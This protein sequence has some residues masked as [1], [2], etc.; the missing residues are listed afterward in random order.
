MIPR[1]LRS[2][3][4]LT[5][6][7]L[8][9]V[10]L[11]VSDAVVTSALRRH[12]VDRVDHQL[13]PI[14]LVMSRLDPGA[15]RLDGGVPLARALDLINAVSV[16]YLDADGRVTHV[17]ST[18]SSPP[19]FDASLAGR[20]TGTAF[21]LDGSWRAVVAP[22]PGGGV[23]VVAASLSTIDATIGRLRLVCLLTGLLVVALLTGVGWL[24]IRA[25]LRPLR[26]I[27][28]SAAAIAGGDLTHRIPDAG[29]PGTEVARLTFVLNTMLTQIERAFAARADSE[30]RMRRFVADV[31]HELRTPL[32]GIKGSA[33]LHLMRGG[34]DETM[35]RID[36]EAG[37][38]AALVEDLLLLARLDE[39]A[40]G[41]LL[42]P[43]P[44]DLRTLAADARHDLLALDRD[45]PV[46][47]TGPGASEP[48]GP[49]LVLGD[50]ARLRQVVSNLVGNV[51]AHTPA[52][53]AVRIGVGRLGDEAIIELAD[54]GP[55]VPG[56]DVE[57][58]FDRFHRGDRSRTREVAIGADFGSARSGP[59]DS[60]PADSGPADSGPADS[61][62]ADSGPA[63]SGPVEGD[64][65]EAGRGGSR[66]GAGLG[67]A[68]VR[69]LVVA[70]GGRVEVR[71]TPGGGATF[72][73]ALPWLTEPPAP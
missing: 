57:R 62:P 68:I 31:S 61:G 7:V 2:R 72:R 4:L 13:V 24:A 60:G 38:L 8:L 29:P 40:A 47:L 71:P 50:E 46:S 58:V 63:D 56:D 65:S 6:V 5:T 34:A 15:V 25:G 33:E 37:R 39:P 10:G 69:S 17:E 3:L 22:R 64:W 18:G 23:V 36:R 70:H 26:T 48:P 67:L 9:V 1:S 21:T 16:A 49:A 44:M 35:R 11:L 41:P 55:G 20:P 66:V 43:A 12:L 52:E 51:H 59:A 14:T 73:I 42:E 53:A 54:S 19:R 27:E 45:R 28:N 30:A 32:F